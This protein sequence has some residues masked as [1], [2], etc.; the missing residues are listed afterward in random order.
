M[1]FQLS[2]EQQFLR[3]TV[4]EFATKEL[5]P[6]AKD[7]DENARIPLSTWQRMAEA[8]LMGLP[9][10]EKYGGADADAISAALA[11]EEIAR[12]C[13]STALSYAAHVGLGSAPI[14]LFGTQDQ[15]ER[16]LKPAA[17]GRYLGAFGLTEPHAGSDA[18]STR[19]TAVREGDEW[20]INGSKMWI[21]NA[22]EA[23][24]VIVTA[25][26]DKNKGK[27]GI[28]AIIIPQ[29]T[30]GVEFGKPE[31]KMG[32]RGSQTYAINFDHVRV[33][34]D[35][36]LGAEGH[37]FVQF[38][39]VLDGGRISIG[40]MAIGLG[41][42]AMEASIAYA[43]EREAFGKPIGAY[44]SISNMIADMATELDAAR[45]MILRAA[46]LK[47][48]GK[49]F[50]S[51]AAMAKLYASEASERACRNAIQIYGGYGYSSEFPLERY[52]RDTRLLTI[53]E[54]TSEILRLVIS[55]GL[56]GELA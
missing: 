35:N 5:A 33:P 51:E 22:A 39:Q 49:P 20:V 48:Q 14:A 53:G 52:Y 13:G 21:T 25:M 16:F 8:G 23:G 44:Q 50:T 18:G 6:K 47:D 4:R 30:P 32:L 31:H 17:E 38:L 10:P 41:V 7:V 2:D 45:L 42:A 29:G 46:W 24:H 3:Q 37:G 55:R 15:K 11:V 36:L 43:R 12:C 19:T 28:S 54:G 9:F 56:L 27:R 1:D 40:A 26:T 34:V